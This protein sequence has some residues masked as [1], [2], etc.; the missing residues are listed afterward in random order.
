MTSKARSKTKTT[1]PGPK[2]PSRWTKAHLDQLADE[3]E[4]W[5]KRPSNYWL[6]DFA[7]NVAG[8]SRTYLADLAREQRSRRFSDTYKKAK[9]MQEAKIV[10]GGLTGKLNPTMAIFTLKNVAGWRD[11]KDLKIKEDAKDTTPQP[12]KL[13]I[14]KPYDAEEVTATTEQHRERVAPA[15]SYP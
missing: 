3:L 15:P 10:K 4:T 12:I 9:A 14:E 8:C 7:I 2:G 1:K 5:M 11:S 6:G 13:V